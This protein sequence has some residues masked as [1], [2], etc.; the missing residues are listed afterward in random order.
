MFH[1]KF[2]NLKS[3]ISIKYLIFILLISVGC[4]YQIVQVCVVFFEFKTKID[5]SI[6]KDEIGIPMVSFCT[7]TRNVFRDKRQEA[8]GLTPAQVYNKTFSFGQLFMSIKYYSIDDEYQGSYYWQ[9]QNLANYEKNIQS[10]KFNST[11]DI[12]IEKTINHNVVCYNFKH[13]RNKVKRSKFTNVIYR[14]VLKLQ[15]RCQFDITLSSKNYF[16]NYGCDNAFKVLG[17]SFFK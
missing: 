9:I 14:F 1:K 6:E 7:Q 8:F 11:V 4:L 3:K 17:D 12:Q 15:N 5:V 16:C 10:R 2:R 13:P